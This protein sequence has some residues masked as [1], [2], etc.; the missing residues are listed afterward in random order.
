MTTNTRVKALKAH[1]GFVE[2]L[3]GFIVLDLCERQH[4]SRLGFWAKR[5]IRLMADG[6]PL[7][8]VL[9]A[10][11][12]HEGADSS[13]GNRVI[14]GRLTHLINNQPAIKRLQ[15][16]LQKISEDAVIQE[17]MCQA[18][19][20]V[21]PY[22]M[23]NLICAQMDLFWCQE[24]ITVLSRGVDADSFEEQVMETVLQLAAGK[25]ESTSPIR[26]FQN[27]AKLQAGAQFLLDWDMYFRG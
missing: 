24:A 22:K 17:A 18:S 15:G 6:L 25:E 8:L 3:Q 20:L 26:N 16:K 21:P 19:T 2:D 13:E 12:D 14:Q 27:R 5:T 11:S 4:V 10:I 7:S 9:I 23:E 1:Q